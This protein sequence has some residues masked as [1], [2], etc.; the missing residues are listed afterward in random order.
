LLEGAK[1]RLT[2]SDATNSIGLDSDL[3][4]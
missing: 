2:L 4:T 3:N 1:H